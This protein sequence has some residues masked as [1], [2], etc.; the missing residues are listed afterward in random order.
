MGLWLFSSF[1]APSAQH[2]PPVA[3]AAFDSAGTDTSSSVPDSGR[4]QLPRQRFSPYRPPQPGFFYTRKS[5]ID[6]SRGTVTTITSVGGVEIGERIVR[7]LDKAIAED[8]APRLAAS[9]SQT[10]RQQGRPTTGGDTGPRIEMQYEIPNLPPVAKTIIGEGPSTLH[11]SGYGRI[12]MSGRSQYRTGETVGSTYQQSKF[13][14]LS[15]QQELSFKIDGTIGSKIY[16]SVDQDTRRISE[17]DN[18]V[19]IR[20]QG[21]EDE[22][23]QEV[24]VGNTNLSLPGTQFVSGGVQHSGLFG[25]K[26]RA[27]FG[28]LEVTMIASQQKSSSQKRTFRGGAQASETKILDA[29]YIPRRFYFLDASY[30]IQ[31]AAALE[32]LRNNPSM[33]DLDIGIVPGSGQRPWA[34]EIVE[35]NLYRGVAATAG[36]VDVKDGFGVPAMLTDSS[37]NDLTLSPYDPATLQAMAEGS[38]GRIR[39]GGWQLIPSTEYYLDPDLGYVDFG[40]SLSDGAIIGVVIKFINQAGVIDSFPKCTDPSVL[41]TKMVKYAPSRS[42]DPTWTYEWRHVY[43]VGARDLSPT[44]FRLEIVDAKVAGTPN[45]PANSAQTYLQLMQ[46]DVASGTD[47]TGPADG[48]VDNN[49]VKLDLKTGLVY[50]PFLE[51]FQEAFVSLEGEGNPALYQETN[52]SGRDKYAL[53]ATYSKAS[54]RIQLGFNIM[55]NTEVVKLN[56]VRLTRNIDYTINYFTGELLFTQSV[57]DQ[58]SQPGADLSID[59]EMN[60]IFKPDQESL[61]GL[62]GVYRLGERGN[63]GG[64]VMYNSERTSSTRVRVGEEPSRMTVFATYANYEFRPSWITTAVDMLPFIESDEPSTLR[65]EG[66]IAQSL[67]NLNTRGTAYLDDFEGAGNRTPIGIGRRGWALASPPVDLRLRPNELDRNRRGKFVWFNPYSR[68]KTIDVFTSLSENELTQ[69]ERFMDVL[70]LWFRPKGTTDSERQASWGGIMRSFGTTG[71][72][73]QKTQFLEIW[74]RAGANPFDPDR[75]GGV[76][77]PTGTPVLHIDLGDM[78]ENSHLSTRTGIFRLTDFNTEDYIINTKYVDQR[79]ESY[80]N[81]GILDFSGNDRGEDVGLDGCPDAYEDGN[82]GCLDTPNPDYPAVTDDPNGDNWSFRHT[83]SPYDFERINGT[84]DNRQDSE[85]QPYPDTEDLNGNGSLDRTNNYLTYTIQLDE[86]SPYAVEETEQ[87]RSGFRLYRIPLKELGMGT[88]NSV[89][90]TAPAFNRITTARMWVDGVRDSALWVTI[91][92]MDFVGNDWEEV[93][94]SGEQFATT[95]VNTQ[96]NKAYTPPPGVERELDA[97][98]G[99]LRREQSLVM[100]IME[101]APGQTYRAQRDLYTAVNLTD[102]RRLRMYVH[103][104]ETG[105]NPTWDHLAAFLRLGLDSTSY[106]ELRIPRLYPGWDERN[107]VDVFIDSLTNLKLT[108]TGQ[109]FSGRDT[110]ST[111]GRLRVVAAQRGASVTLPSLSSIR[112]LQIGIVNLSDHT[113]RAPSTN[114]PI[115]VWFDDLRLEGVRNIAG[116]AYRAGLKMQMADLVNLQVSTNRQQIGFGSIQN[117][118]GSGTETRSYT[119]AV[120]RFRLDKLLPPAWRVSVPVNLNY[121]VNTNVPRLKRGS[122]IELIDQRDKDVERARTATINASTSFV[123]SS[124]SRN[125][126]IGLTLDRVGAGVTYSL[127]HGLTPGLTS[128]DSS[129]SMSYTGRFNYDLTPRRPHQLRILGWVPDRLPGKVEETEFAYL[130]TSLRFDATT[131]FRADSSWSKQKVL[132]RDTTLARGQRVFTISEAYRIGFQPFRS[133]TTAYDMSLNRDL[134]DA[135][136]EDTG[137]G[138]VMQSLAKNIF[139]NRE[140]RRSQNTSINYSPPWPWWLGQSYTYTNQYNDNSDP[141]TTSGSTSGARQ[142]EV[143]NSRGYG[144]SSMT[145]KVR[146]ILTRFSGETGGTGGGMRRGGMAPAAPRR[147]VSTDTTGGFSLLR[148]LRATAGFGGNHLENVVGRITFNERFMGTQI[149][150]SLRPDL[151]YQILG[152]GRHPVL[153]GVSYTIRPQN[154]ISQDLGWDVSSGLQLPL[155]MRLQAKYAFRTTKTMGARDTTRSR[156]ITFPDV[157]YSWDGLESLPLLRIVTTRSEVQS[158]FT[159]RINTS[160]TRTGGLPERLD[161]RSTSYVLSPLFS[162]SILWKNSIRSTIRSTWDQTLDERYSAA[163]ISSTQTTNWGVTLNTTYELQ[164]SRG[165]SKPWGGK[166]QLAGNI[167]LSLDGSYSGSYAVGLGANPSTGGDLVQGHTR[168]WSIKP[169]AQYQFS[170]TFTGQ[171]QIEVGSMTD[172]RNHYTMKTRAV[173]ITGELRFN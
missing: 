130:P 60:P 122:D 135:L 159:R 47:L 65:L 150:D 89:G 115:Q 94:Q 34:R 21:E 56:G 104:P 22:I 5:Q 140:I 50:F 107:Y 152:I 49:R 78:S 76:A 7:P 27:Q 29:E 66:E 79:W 141:R 2:L 57:A 23:V 100:Q 4:V 169:Q 67:P 125:P 98:T 25:I 82:G 129:H 170:R 41:V 161:R 26:A 71:V 145:F 88:V 142:Y 13:P 8:I 120:D 30:R 1:G 70:N 74:V 155:R 151:K 172:L 133:L 105:I 44:D 54:T 28:D 123:K 93:K 143:T 18:N 137:P 3:P 39:Q 136:E 20:Y 91:A 166:W 139:R 165:I 75:I 55:E 127:S 162:W 148:P 126:A 112:V 111:D 160:W 108:D 97:L 80:R 92:S 61:V 146:D 73:L 37:G 53:V 128:R 95:T 157:G 110:I 106:Y 149:P 156:D 59:Y 118:Q 144:I 10:R 101:I 15:M 164:T 16:V 117:K 124:Q 64:I 163:G 11:I 99:A 83:G 85:I 40:T 153:P 168:T 113:I 171:A 33:K 19:H 17:L 109:F 96:D 114:Q 119:V 62:S 46:L 31:Y 32:K 6:F 14:T 63:L 158:S 134:A 132:G 154:S 121:S 87:A 68:V 72:D 48:L 58:V 43:F 116:R 84:Q 86:N 131:T 69:S 45:T 24:E 90:G 77:R 51:P 9:L 52:L 147:P 102:Y 103:G 42:T 81:N 12:T 38:G 138:A 173:M 35:V 36:Q 167:N